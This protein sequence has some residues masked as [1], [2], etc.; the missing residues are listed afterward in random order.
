MVPDREPAGPRPYAAFGWQGITLTV[1]SSWDLVYVSGDRRRGE[2]RLADREAVR[3]VARWDRSGGN[4][5]VAQVLDAHI[6]RVTKQARKAGHSVTVQRDLKLASPPG[7]EVQSY[8]W[9]ADAQ[10]VAMLSRCAECSSTVHLQLTGRRDEG[11]KSL[12][13]TVFSSL[14]DHAS[15]GTAWSFLDVEFRVPAG[16][17]LHKRVLQAGCV[18]MT[19]RAGRARLEFVRAAMAQVLLAKRDLADWF[20]EFY[21]RQLKRRTYSL[22][23]GNVKGHPAVEVEGRPWRWLN[24]LAAFG[25]RKILRG[26]CWHCEA[27]N[28]LLICCLDGPARHEA[29]LKDAVDSFRCCAA[30]GR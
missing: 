10:G 30:A 13:R 24:P 21:A 14:R 23:P 4:R 11:L 26:A 20:R 28:R 12:A 9:E 8:R 25:R 16:F 15:D 27:S 6:S 19:F 17:E 2:V 7:K 29:L 1:P 3:L 22:R 18:R 5:P